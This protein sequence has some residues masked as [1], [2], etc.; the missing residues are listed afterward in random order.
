MRWR[1]CVERTGQRSPF[2]CHAL[3]CE[4]TAKLG[5]R[6]SG[7]G[8]DRYLECKYRDWARANSASALMENGT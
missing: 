7:T 3:E 8:R 4:P 1:G 2:S 6:V 5:S